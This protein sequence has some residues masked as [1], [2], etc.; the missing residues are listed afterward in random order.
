[1]LRRKQPLATNQSTGLRL[2]LGP[3]FSVLGVAIALALGAAAQISKQVDWSK[4][5]ILAATVG[6]AVLNWL[7]ARRTQVE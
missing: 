3:L 1:P 4:S 6:A 2:P 7:W 5:L